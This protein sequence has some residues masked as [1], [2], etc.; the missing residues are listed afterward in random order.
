MPGTPLFHL[1]ITNRKRSRRKAAF[2]FSAKRNKD[3]NNE[4][5]P[6]NPTQ[7]K[8]TREDVIAAIKELAAKMGRQPRLSELR[9]RIPVTQRLI[10]RLF[11]S[12]SEALAASGLEPQ[13][14]G[15]KLTMEKMFTRWATVVR[16]LKKIPTVADYERCTGHS[17]YT[18]QGRFKSWVQVPAEMFQYAQ[19]NGLKEEWEDVLELITNH[20]FQNRAKVSGSKTCSISGLKARI[21]PGRPVYGEWFLAPSPMAFAP[22]NEMGVVSLFSALAT[23]LGFIITWIGTEYPDCE[24]FREVEPER[25]QLW[26]IEFEF[27]SRNFLA[28]G[29]DPA[30]CD[31]IVCWEDNF[32]DSPVPVL[33]LKSAVRALRE[34]ERE[35]SPRRRGDTE[36]T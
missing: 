7:K 15:Y 26:V 36:N 9:G 33:E 12:Y 20:L 22:R 31:L 5:T 1:K 3:M 28:H 13:G 8:L 25:W 6:A 21:L 30:R 23:Q 27:C 32:P 19:E 14:S 35:G 17:S 18:L 4:T 34:A 24:V 16:E 29:H 11:S 10:Y 2:L